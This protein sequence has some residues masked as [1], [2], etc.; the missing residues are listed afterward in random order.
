MDQ[1]VLLKQLGN[2]KNQIQELKS[3]RVDEAQSL[4]VQKKQFLSKYKNI[5]PE[6]ERINLIR[7]INKELEANNEKYLLLEL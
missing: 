4:L 1:E 6:K 2:L 3:E 5:L 7:E